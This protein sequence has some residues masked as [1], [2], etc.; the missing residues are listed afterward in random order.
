[1]FLSHRIYSIKDAASVVTFY[2]ITNYIVFKN[3]RDRAQI[4]HLAR[5]VYL[6]EILRRS[7][8]RHYIEISRIFVA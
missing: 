1:M 6:D 2:I 4:R 7:I 8:L 5:Q 3:P